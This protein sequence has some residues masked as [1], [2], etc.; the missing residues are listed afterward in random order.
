[1]RGESQIRI[2]HLFQF[3][4]RN[5]DEMNPASVADILRFWELQGI[6]SERKQVYKDIALLQDFGVDVIRIKST[7]NHYFIGNRLFELPE[8]KLLVDAV[9]SS[10]FI[11]SKKSGDLIRKLG[12]LTSNTQAEQLDRHIYMDGMPK[13]SNEAIYYIVDTIQSSIQS[14]QQISFQY[15]EYLPTKEK[16]LKHQGYR[17][18]FTPYALIW[19]RDHYYVVGWSEK[20]MKLSQ[21][22]VDRMTSVEMMDQPGHQLLGFE[23]AEYVQ[24][25]FGMYPDD[26]QM[27]TLFCEN[28]VMRSIIDRFG[29]GVRTEVVDDDHFQAIVEVAPSP[30]FFGW[31][32]TFA[33]KI[34]ILK[35]DN[36]LEEMRQMASW[37]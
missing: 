30:P 11:T 1:M 23:P 25:V 26:L 4:Y 28:D 13:P 18:Q 34:R 9:E 37:L 20:H 5:T 14:N 29:E 27:V 32:F 6:C 35:P 19:N 31:I 12:Q 7:Q 15:Y 8:L 22:R 2:L 16:V 33:G 36:V 10:R 24:K 3:L 21:F 17:Y